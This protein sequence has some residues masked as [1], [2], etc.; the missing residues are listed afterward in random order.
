MT[1]VGGRL[2]RMV[3]LLV[4]SVIFFGLIQEAS[5]F[6]IKHYL[7]GRWAFSGAVRVKLL[8]LKVSSKR[9]GIVVNA[10]PIRWRDAEFSLLHGLSI[11][12]IEVGKEK[13][14]AA[15]IR[16]VF[17]EDLRPL[18]AG[19]VGRAEMR[20]FDP[21]WRKLSSVSSASK[22]GGAAFSLPVDIDIAHL[23]LDAPGGKWRG[24][25][26]VRGENEGANGTFVLQMS[27]PENCKG[28]VSGSWEEKSGE[29]FFQLFM[30]ERAEA[31]F[32]FRWKRSEFILTGDYFGNE[33]NF[34]VNASGLWDKSADILLWNETPNQRFNYLPIGV[35]WNKRAGR[36]IPTVDFEP[37]V[38]TI[39][40]FELGKKAWFS[41]GK[42]TVDFFVNPV[43]TMPSGVCLHLEGT[44][45][46]EKVLRGLT[47]K[48]VLNLYYDND[49]VFTQNLPEENSSPSD[50]VEKKGPGFLLSGRV[51][52]AGK[53]RKKN[54]NT[55]VDDLADFTVSGEI[56][57]GVV[58]R[59]LFRIEGLRT[60]FSGKV[61]GLD[62]RVDGKL[63]WNAVSKSGAHFVPGPLSPLDGAFS[64]T[65]EGWYIDEGRLNANGS[66]TW[67]LSLLK[68]K[69]A[70]S[71][72]GGDFCAAGV[73]VRGL[74]GEASF[75]G[76]NA[77]PGAECK[78]K[79][80]EIVY[81]TTRL[82]NASLKGGGRLNNLAFDFSV[83]VP[84]LEGSA[85]G[86]ITV[87]LTS[88][89]LKARL[90]GGTLSMLE[91][92]I[93]IDGLSTDWM[94][95]NEASP[96]WKAEDAFIWGKRVNPIS[97]RLNV[98]GADT[99]EATFP[100]WSGTGEVKV[101][102]NAG[103]DIGPR[104]KIALTGVELSPVGKFLGN[105]IELPL[106]IKKG[107]GSG[108]VELPLEN[109]P[110]GIVFSVT[111]DEAELNIGEGNFYGVSGTLK[112]KYDNKALKCSS[113]GMSLE[114]GKVPVALNL[115]Y[116][117]KKTK[118][119]FDCPETDL[120]SLQNAVFDFL[121]EY[122]GYGKMSGRGSVRG[123]FRYRKG[124]A[125]LK[126][127]VRTRKGAFTSEDGALL[128]RGVKGSVPISLAFGEGLKES[129]T[130]PEA[131]I[132][133]KDYE[134]SIRKVA[135]SVFTVKRI[136]MKSHL[137]GRKL[138][139]LL[140]S[141]RLWGGDIDGELS[142]R[143]LKGDITYSGKMKLKGLSLWEFCRESRTLEGALSG[144]FSG[145]LNIKAS[146][147]G[148]GN[149]RGLLDIRVDKNSKEKKRIS[150]D[151]IVRIGGGKIRRVLKS[152][153]L[154]YDRASLKCGLDNGVLTFY[155]LELSHRANPLKSIM[156]RDISFELRIPNNNSISIWKLI[157]QIKKLEE[158]SVPDQDAGNEK[159]AHR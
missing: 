138:I 108:T 98:H 63:H 71:V 102:L 61:E 80:R 107:K 95:E 132:R 53:G 147:L 152:H 74:V 85:K 103:K 111:P 118:L 82:D 43:N 37:G 79:A 16:D 155:N 133:G 31:Y 65:G 101:A 6:G 23:E 46:A 148:M 121:P 84:Q 140:D 38:V 50:L 9:G 14:P 142:L 100:V 94:D 83:G 154:T 113:S 28:S 99:V 110:E 27:G 125:T 75:T 115:V 106:E 96:G 77:K 56:K 20:V 54:R 21:A 22:K 3:G 143:I 124:I 159:Q 60:E 33:G 127:V 112:G 146:S 48:T 139:A 13:N 156:R 109:L 35:T 57:K 78:L 87:D 114:K 145:T 32:D 39:P 97:G 26:E 17:L 134:L 122:L 55:K 91:K 47:R 34:G 62:W 42:L 153:V 69:T 128:I 18:C 19:T 131:G 51:E 11:G 12:E 70:L 86:K 81:S 15:R 45:H 123:A 40:K 5:A 149:A 144:Q 10:V 68:G 49:G 59:G 90:Q 29:L 67:K 44:L 130:A 58:F 136:R 4:W 88:P 8:F 2:R 41:G 89:P 66:G 141:G 158:N 76:A 119:S 157:E 116:D 135:Y 105:W 120:A 52:G 151:F 36:L 7:S 150:R 25:A 92:K 30:P 137:I 73:L 72:H 129:E 93:V 24:T 126:G 117:G 104:V 1:R 64:L